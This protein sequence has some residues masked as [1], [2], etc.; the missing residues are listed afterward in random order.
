MLNEIWQ[1][2]LK[3]ILKIEPNFQPMLVSLAAGGVGARLRPLQVGIR[4]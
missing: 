3:T 1:V 2:E 4:S